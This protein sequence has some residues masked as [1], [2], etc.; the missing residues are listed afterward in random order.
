MEKNNTSVKWFHEK[1]WEL[2]MLLEKQQISV[3]K[4]CVVYYDILKQAKEMEKLQIINA[5]DGFP[6]ENRHLDGEQYY[7]ETY[8]KE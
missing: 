7:T 3:G 1:T 5:V 6:I 8:G 2:K 4:Y